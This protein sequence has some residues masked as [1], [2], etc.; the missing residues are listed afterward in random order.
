MHYY[1]DCPNCGG[2]RVESVKHG[3][4]HTETGSQVCPSRRDPEEVLEIVRRI[5]ERDHD[6]LKRLGD[7]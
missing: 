7:S 5:I 2:K 1:M 3:V 6:L 4:F